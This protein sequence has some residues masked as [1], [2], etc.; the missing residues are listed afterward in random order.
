MLLNFYCAFD[1]KAGAFMRAFLMASDGEAMRAFSDLVNDHATLCGMHP[2]DFT[3]YKIGSY[4]DSSGAI[5]PCKHI[6]LGNGVAF[7]ITEQ[8]NADPQRD[9]TSIRPGPLS[10]NSPVEL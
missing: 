4:D 6:S 7:K 9:E 8:R 1:S 5:V 2:D 3:L 10:G